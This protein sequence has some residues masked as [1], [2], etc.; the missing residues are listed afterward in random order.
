MTTLLT[1]TS[2]LNLCLT[3]TGLDSTCTPKG[4]GYDIVSVWKVI[5]SDWCST[6]HESLPQENLL[7][8][9]TVELNLGQVCWAAQSWVHEIRL[10]PA[11][12][13]LWLTWNL[14][15][16]WL[17]SWSLVSVLKELCWSV[18]HFTETYQ[19]LEVG[20]VLCLNLKML[21]H[22]HQVIKKMDDLKKKNLQKI[23]HR[24]LFL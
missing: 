6:W 12:S 14:F 16:W 13:S 18:H 20:S 8:Q 9:I 22:H 19:K 17:N 5:N 11:E 2:F 21:N 24:K 15:W 7:H 3:L 23:L 4:H 10:Q 1:C